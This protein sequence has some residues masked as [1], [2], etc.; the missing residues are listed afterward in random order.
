M[1]LVGV[2][3]GVVSESD[4]GR[5]VNR[6]GQ[7]IDIWPTSLHRLQVTVGHFLRECPSWLH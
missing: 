2:S 3:S 1:S 5:K 6:C 4:W 7:S